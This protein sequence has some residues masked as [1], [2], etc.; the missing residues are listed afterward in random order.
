MSEELGY[1]VLVIGDIY[2]NHLIRFVSNLKG[3]NDNAII[4]VVATRNNHELSPRVKMAVR[5]I[6]YFEDYTTGNKYVRE[7]KKI[8]GIR[9]TLRIIGKKRHYNIVNIHFPIEEYGFAV[10]SLRKL[11]DTMLIT[12]WGSDIY[13]SGKRGRLLLRPL[14]HKA[15]RVC[16]TGNRFNKDVKRLFNLPDAKFINLDIG[17]ETIDYISEKRKDICAED[18]RRR[19]ELSGDYFI[20]CGYNAHQ[21]QHHLL[22]IDAINQVKDKLPKDTV[23][24]FPLT[25]PKEESYINEIKERVKMYC[26]RAVF[27]E[28]YLQIEDLFLMRQSTDMFIHVQSTDANAQSVQEYILLGKNVLNGSWLRYSELERDGIPYH[29]TE[30][31][32]TLPQAIL[33]SFEQGPVEVSDSII[34]YISAYGWKPWI[35]KWNEYFLSTLK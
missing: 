1:S 20:T 30:S 24:I 5:D 6:F 11:G 8:I 23:L 31:L 35:K 27:Y 26:L 2:D 21:E 16:G 10:G 18:A 13:R 19:L 15:D 12:P 3:E 17:S 34:D 28:N 9:R 7:I 32:D 25:Y 29:L 14:F 22:I 4:D 33:N